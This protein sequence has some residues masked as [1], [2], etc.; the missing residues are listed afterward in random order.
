[1]AAA[2]ALTNV[3]V[4]PLVLE[5]AG[6]DREIG[7]GLGL[8][9]NAMKAMTWLGAADFLRERAVR[10][11]AN[12]WCELESGARIGS[13]SFA[14]ADERY[15]ERYYTAHRGD[16]LD[17]LVRLVPPARVRLDARVV[18][19]DEGPDG[20]TVRL[21][22]GEEVEGDLLVGA[23]GLRSRIRAALRR[24]GGPLHR[25]RHVARADPARTGAGEVRAANRRLARAEPSLDA[26]SG[27]FRPLQ[28]E[29]LRA[30]R[31]SSPRSLGTRLPTPR[32]CGGR[33]SGRA[34]TSPP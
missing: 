11:E 32:T 29:R 24:G 13:H 1:M 4:E 9:A 26:R 21:A 12:V 16:L 27:A 23:D 33:S 22:S 30:G 28:P 5:Q 3:G 17:S 25:H 6:A 19:F 31:G 7:A 8:A 14:L 18:G 20:V 34:A 2:V 10:T 15:G